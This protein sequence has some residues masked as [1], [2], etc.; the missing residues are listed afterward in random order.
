MI[1]LLTLILNVSKIFLDLLGYLMPM[2]EQ[3]IRKRAEE[4]R[5]KEEEMKK[6][7]RPKG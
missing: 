2:K 1:K 4:L 5:K 7:G 6:S 3:K